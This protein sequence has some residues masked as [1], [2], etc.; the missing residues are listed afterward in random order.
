MRLLLF[1]WKSRA[2]QNLPW[3]LLRRELSLLYIRFYV[4]LM[5]GFTILYIL[6]HA[7]LVLV[8]VLYSFWIPQIFCTAYQD[9]KP[10]LTNQFVIGMSLSR[11]CIP[12]YF[13]ACPVNFVHVKN[14]WT[15]SLLLVFYLLFQATIVV[16]QQTLGPRFFI[17]KQF[18]P[19]KYDYRRGFPLQEMECVI[20][21]ESIEGDYMVTPCNH[22][23]HP[24]CLEQWM[25]FK[26]DCPTC[27]STL[28]PL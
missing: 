11:L 12:L 14:S 17:P 21:M 19:A 9:S 3:Q 1:I 15:T 22:V 24:K 23:F 25:D 4:S 7:V 20:C 2:P 27:R 26:M 18:L 13:L 8:F 28:P 16:L 6:E 5:S 10:P